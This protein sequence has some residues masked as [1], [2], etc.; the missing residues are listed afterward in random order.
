M[1]ETIVVLLLAVV[2]TIAGLIV[3]AIVVYNQYQKLKQIAV[4]Q[5]LINLYQNQLNT[6]IYDTIHR[7]IPTTTV[8]NKITDIT[9]Q[10]SDLT[11]KL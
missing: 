4:K 6:A 1:I 5:Q 8:V 2:F 11:E 7:D 10:L 3:L 9:T